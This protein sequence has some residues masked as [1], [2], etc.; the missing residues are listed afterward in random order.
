[1]ALGKL[2]NFSELQFLNGTITANKWDMMY[3]AHY[4]SSLE[5]GQYILVII[6]R[7][8]AREK[9]ARVVSLSDPTF[10]A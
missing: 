2:L 10:S 1:M 9:N 8:S 5:N 6:N 4:V 7:S 3:K